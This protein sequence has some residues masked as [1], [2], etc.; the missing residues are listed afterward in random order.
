LDSLVHGPYEVVENDSHSFR[1]RMGSDVV[2]ITSDRI[3]PAP[4]KPR[5]TPQGADGGEEDS[6]VVPCS[7]EDPREAE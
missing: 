3:M 6:V 1:L 4:R 5:T 2:R 7:K